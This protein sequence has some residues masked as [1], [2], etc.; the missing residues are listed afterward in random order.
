MSRGARLQRF[1]GAKADLGARYNKYVA[2]ALLTWAQARFAI[3]RESRSV[4]REYQSRS[5]ATLSGRPI[6]THKK[7][8]LAGN[9]LAQKDTK[10]MIRQ[11]RFID[12]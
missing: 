2:W 4:S 9:T 11:L 7:G 10:I 12:R 5:R 6:G 3:D 8:R 1:N